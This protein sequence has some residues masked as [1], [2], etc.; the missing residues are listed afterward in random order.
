MLRPHQQTD[1]GAGIPFSRSALRH[2]ARR[3]LKNCNFVACGGLNPFSL[4]LSFPS[5]LFYSSPRPL[6]LP[7]LAHCRLAFTDRQP[8]DQPILKV[9]TPRTTT[10][11]KKVGPHP[12]QKV[13]PHPA[14]KVD[15]DPAPEIRAQ[16]SGV[17]PS[18]QRGAG[19]GCDVENQT[20]KSSKSGAA[21]FYS[22]FI[23]VPTFRAFSES[24]SLIHCDHT[25]LPDPTL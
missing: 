18:T 22:V 2:E 24:G 1:L 11:P 7:L 23:M 4:P 5:P 25:T 3:C 10:G 15:P 21:T 20:R 14:R 19:G 13:G 9:D 17:N 16:K 12:Y 6:L 8:V